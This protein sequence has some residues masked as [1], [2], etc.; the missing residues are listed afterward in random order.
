MPDADPSPL[1][2]SAGLLALAAL[3]LGSGGVAAGPPGLAG[4]YWPPCASASWAEGA[5]GAST[6]RQ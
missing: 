3:L 4:V 1:P 2:A 5:E 6:L